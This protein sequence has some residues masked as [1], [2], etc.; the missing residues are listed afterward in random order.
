MM[1]KVMKHKCD[2]VS[3][4]S[5]AMI[6]SLDMM[7]HHLSTHQMDAISKN[8]SRL[9]VQHAAFGI[10][11]K[12]YFVLG[13]VLLSTV[14]HFLGTGNGQRYWLRVQSS[15]NSL[16]QYII[17]SMKVESKQE[18]RRQK[19]LHRQN[20]RSSS[21]NLFHNNNV[22]QQNLNHTM[23]SASCTVDSGITEELS[24]SLNDF[25][26]W[27]GNARNPAVE[28]ETLKASKS[29]RNFLLS[30]S[31]VGNSSGV[32]KSRRNL[33][34]TPSLRNLFASSNDDDDGGHDDRTTTTTTTSNTNNNGRTQQHGGL[35][36]RHL[37]S[38]SISNILDDDHPHNVSLSSFLEQNNHDSTG[39][40]SNSDGPSD[41]PPEM[42]SPIKT[43]RGVVGRPGLSKSHR[44][45]SRRDFAITAIALD[46]DDMKS[47]GTIKSVRSLMTNMS[48][49]TVTARK[50]TAH[51]THGFGRPQLSKSISAKAAL[52]GRSR[53]DLS[54]LVTDSEDESRSPR[55]VTS[56]KHQ[57]QLSLVHPKSTGAAPSFRRP[58]RD[59]AVFVTD[60][61]VSAGA[62]ISSKGR[63][64][65]R[66]VVESRAAPPPPLS[67]PS[68]MRGGHGDQ[69]STPRRKMIK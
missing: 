22:E 40:G 23:N 29:M 59:C 65:V 14:E 25:D 50:T 51:T 66:P 19:F 62:A 69:Q 17:E 4:H 45:H 46:E 43:P 11:S 26:L 12:H 2:N 34:L 30:T 9:G 39:S 5:R 48:S 8:L 21:R 13:Q 15:W 1:P 55:S 10:Q 49:P 35:S 36:R 7:V 57:Q 58:R 47:V 56:P 68:M 38:A 16:F 24:S 33:L 18:E 61:P 3:A 6:M 41:L 67:S 44:Q 64:G 32:R 42:F 27:N 53:R 60:S 63:R 52:G 28:D 54:I 37:L 20:Q 31:T